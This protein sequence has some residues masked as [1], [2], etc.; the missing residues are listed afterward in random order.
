M[1][2][3]SVVPITCLSVP[4]DT[5]KVACLSLISFPLAKVEAVSIYSLILSMALLVSLVTSLCLVCDSAFKV[6]KDEQQTTNN[7]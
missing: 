3:T 6:L 5:L 4:I 2:G 1:S 7:K